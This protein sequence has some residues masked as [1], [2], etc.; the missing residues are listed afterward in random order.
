MRGD[1][2]SAERSNHALRLIMP[3]AS[4][5]ACASRERGA[6]SNVKASRRQTR[7][8]EDDAD[9]ARSRRGRLSASSGVQ[10]GS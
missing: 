10:L 4:A 7:G 2:E 9:D 5:P 3:S 6:A 1:R 8:D